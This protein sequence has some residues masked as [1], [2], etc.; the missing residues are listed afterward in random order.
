MQ[1]EIAALSA[2]IVNVSITA[3]LY[4]RECNFPDTIIILVATQAP[5]YLT[6]RV[7]FC[8]QFE[9][10]ALNSH[11]LSAIYR[12]VNVINLINHLTND[13]F[14]ASINPA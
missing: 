10:A 3:R 1:T 2:V 4:I 6:R 9:R 8:F 11:S 12:V 7:A 14:P 5:F 13:F